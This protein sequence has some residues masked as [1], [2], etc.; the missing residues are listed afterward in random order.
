MLDNNPRV[1]SFINLLK[2]SSQEELVWMHGYLSAKLGVSWG[3]AASQSVETA[4]PKVTRFTLAYGT[5]TG[6]SKRLATDLAKAAKELGFQVKLV[7]L[8]QYR[9]KD[10]AKETYFFLIV[11]TQG[12]GEPPASANAFF[13]YIQQGEL[14]L[15]AMNFAVLGLGDSAYPQ[16]CQAGID[17]DKHLADRGGKRLLPLVKCDVAFDE[18]GKQWLTDIAAALSGASVQTALPSAVATPVRPGKALYQGEILTNINLNDEPSAKETHHIEIRCEGDIDYAPGD[19][20]GFQPLN[21]SDLVD[22]VLAAL[23][24]SGDER[25]TFRGETAALQEVLSRKV[26]LTYLPKRVIDKYAALLARPIECGRVNFDE[27]LIAHPP[28]AVELGALLEIMEPI[29][30]RLY[31]ISSSPAAHPGELHLTVARA[32]F[33]SETGAKGEGLCS[34]YLCRLPEETEIEF[35]IHKNSAFKLPAPENDVIMIGPGTGIAPFRS[36]LF[37]RDAAGAS[38][39]NWLFFGDQHFV[40]DFLYQTELQD[41]LK[42]GVLDRLD[43]AFSRDQAEKVY[44]QH[45]LLENGVAVYEWIEGGASVYVCGTKDP[46]SVDVEKA[47]LQIIQ[48]HGGLETEAAQSYLAR[49]VEQGRYLK[50]VY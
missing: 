7:A 9:L 35:Y 34:G 44:V 49:L 31:S 30:P 8:D 16:F 3:G 12:D 41:F 25:V 26:N 36:F 13:D 2:T 20:A 46:M 5:E 23:E 21:P 38:G 43:V 40:T 28:G 37:E 50:D 27:L 14:K 17:A 45:R 42:T 6:N 32:T 19:A 24:K 1:T 29:A 39:R 4:V 22:R 47:L 10:L 15:D 11:S 48:T 18:E 33:T